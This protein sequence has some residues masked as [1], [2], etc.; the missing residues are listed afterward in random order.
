MRKRGD[1]WR[2]RFTTEKYDV[3]DEL[4]IVMPDL[5]AV[6]KEQQSYI[7][8]QFGESYDKLFCGNRT[9]KQYRKKSTDDAEL[10]QIDFLAE[11][12]KKDVS[13][14][15]I[16]GRCGTLKN[17]FWCGNSQ[18]W[19]EVEPDLIRPE[20][21]A[22]QRMSNPDPIP[23]SV[24]EK[25]ENNLNKLPEPIARMWI[26]AFFTAMRPSELAS[27]KKDCLVQEGSHWKIVWWRKKGK[28]QHEVPVSRTIAKVV[29][30]QQDYIEQLWGKERKTGLEQ[31]VQMY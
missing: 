2:I 7:K 13:A 5:V 27:L 18:G 17:F 10:K 16:N 19:F 15:A 14:T 20:D 23:D 8:Q 30:E 21:Y 12:R 29:Q 11:E 25:I 22:K 4:P 1:Q 6:I 9:G 24:R 3:E 28:N 26:I 31:M